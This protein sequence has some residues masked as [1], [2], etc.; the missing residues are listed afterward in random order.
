MPDMNCALSALTLVA[1]GA[2]LLALASCGDTTE[3]GSCETDKDCEGDRI[4]H[5]GECTDPKAGSAE[6]VTPGEVCAGTPEC[7]EDTICVSDGAS[8][9]CAAVCTSNAQ[10]NSGCCAPVSDTDKSVCSPD[11]FCMGAGGGTG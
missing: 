11:A 5:D 1:V 10:C 3:D 6:C 9:V 4:C 7:C 8:S 2:P